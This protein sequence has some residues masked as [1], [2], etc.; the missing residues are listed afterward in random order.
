MN[1]SNH[2]P[3]TSSPDQE[4]ID[5][6]ARAA[7]NDLRRPAPAAGLAH[8]QR[9]HLRRQVTRLAVVCTTVVA[10]AVIGT[11][12][13]DRGRSDVAPAVMD[14]VESSPVSTVTSTPAQSEPSTPPSVPPLVAGRPVI[15]STGR[16][17][18]YNA[19]TQQLLDPLTAAVVGEEPIDFG[20]SRAALDA[21]VA[22]VAAQQ[23]TDLGGVVYGFDPAT[24]DAGTLNL[25]PGRDIDL[26]GQAPVTVGGAA[27]STLPTKAISLRVTSN[28]KHVVTESTTC[29]E[30][31]VMGADGRGTSLPFV[32]AITVFDARHPELRGRAIPSENFGGTSISPDGRFLLVWQRFSDDARLND[33]FIRVFDLDTISEVDLG[34][35]SSP[36]NFAEGRQARFTGPWIGPSTLAGLRVCGDSTEVV[37][38]DLQPGGTDL[39]VAVPAEVAPFVESFTLEF[40]VARYITPATTWF[41]FCASSNPDTPLGCWIGHGSESL[42]GAQGIGDVSFLPLGF[43]PGG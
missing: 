39:R 34:D 23:G 43:Y 8:V 3:A 14:S 30:E 37:V 22:D 18:I 33:H 6:R 1:H 15:Y 35:L 17:D 5:A 32:V 12:A 7:G 21:Y 27:G 4:R 31:G 2:D 26:C 20:R 10:V 9:V 40:D 29:P 25:V 38:R 16:R 41:S 13:F 42:I 11:F 36:C 19:T 28:S 24:Y